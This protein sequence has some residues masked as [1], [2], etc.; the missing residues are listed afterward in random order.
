MTIDVE[1]VNED[2][3]DVAKAG[4]PGVAFFRCSILLGQDAQR[5]FVGARS[6]E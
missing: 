6:H 1:G 2:R 5:F 3:A 4:K